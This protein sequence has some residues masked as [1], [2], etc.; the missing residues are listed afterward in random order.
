MADLRAARA[1]VHLKKHDHPY[2]FEMPVLMCQFLEQNL[3]RLLT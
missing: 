2:V 3:K 1:S